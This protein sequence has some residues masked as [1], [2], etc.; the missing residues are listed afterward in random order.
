MIIEGLLTTT[1]ADGAPHVA[2]MGPLVDVELKNW[3]L[4]PFSSSTTFRNLQ[5]NPHCVFHVIDDVVPL[6]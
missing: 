1:A 4:R 3:T 6:V 5:S 2:P